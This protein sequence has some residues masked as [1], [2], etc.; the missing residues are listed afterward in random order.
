MT[1]Y[2]AI[3]PSD[4]AT[5]GCRQ[6]LYLFSAALQQDPSALCAYSRLQRRRYVLSSRERLHAF[7]IPTDSFSHGRFILRLVVMAITSPLTWPVQSSPDRSPR[8]RKPAY[9]HGCCTRGRHNRVFHGRSP[10]PPARRE[11]PQITGRSCQQPWFCS[12]FFCPRP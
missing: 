3:I 11:N 2:Q 1:A 5:A 9:L 8:V 12:L 7:C 10:P 4:R 6:K